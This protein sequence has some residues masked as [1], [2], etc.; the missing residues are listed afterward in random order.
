MKREDFYIGQTVYLFHIRNYDRNATLE[1]RIKEVKVI[2]VGR[3]YLT[4]DHWGKHEFDMTKNF[5]EKTIYSPSFELF[6]TKEAI[7]RVVETEMA[8]KEVR[9]KLDKYL[10]SIPLEGVREIL[11]VI[12]KYTEEVKSNE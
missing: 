10:N 11:A 6:L 5:R 12:G 8:R 2:S 9:N 4:V 7:Y 3:K 1:E